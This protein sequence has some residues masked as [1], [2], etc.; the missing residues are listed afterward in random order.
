MNVVP[1]ILDFRLLR[2]SSDT[3][4][5]SGFP[6]TLLH[7]SFL[8]NVSSVVGNGPLAYSHLL[9]YCKPTNILQPVSSNVFRGDAY[10]GGMRKASRTHQEKKRVLRSLNVSI[11]LA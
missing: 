1:R 10:Y 9:A 5:I 2:P 7:L 3:P 11:E 8:E 4:N 6:K